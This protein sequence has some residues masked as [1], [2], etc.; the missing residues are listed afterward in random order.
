MKHMEIH[1]EEAQQT[2]S[3]IKLEIH[4]KTHN[5]IVKSKGKEKMINAA[6]EK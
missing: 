3:R 6:G 5:Q 4:T 1:I 2:P